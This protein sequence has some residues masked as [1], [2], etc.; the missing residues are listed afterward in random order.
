VPFIRLRAA[1]IIVA[2][3]AA[4]LALEMKRFSPQLLQL[5]GIDD[6]TICIC[7]LEQRG[8]QAVGARWQWTC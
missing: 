4:I 7:N 8:Q 6:V 5:I 2:A 3:L 1:G